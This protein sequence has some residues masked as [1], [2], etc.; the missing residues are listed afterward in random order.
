LTSH[1]LQDTVTIAM[2]NVF[3]RTLSVASHSGN[4]DGRNHNANHHCSVFIGSAFKNAVIG[5][6]TL[7]TSGKDYRA[8]GID[9]ISGLGSDSAD[10]PYEETLAS[11]GK[12][13]GVA[14]GVSQSVLDDQITKGKVITAA[15]AS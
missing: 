4:S 15:L 6:V 10:I 7:Q 3:G 13:L 1:G 14:T 12:T 11:V 5:G 9:S 8:Q 2:Q